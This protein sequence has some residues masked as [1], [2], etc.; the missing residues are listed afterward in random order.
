[1]SSR[2]ANIHANAAAITKQERDVEKATEDLAKERE[3]M[4]KELG[5]YESGLKELGDAGNWLESLERDIGVLEEWCDEREEEERMEREEEERMEREEQERLER[6]ERERRGGD[7]G[8]V[9]DGGGKVEG[10]KSS[11]KWWG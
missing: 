6:E 2:A 9:V 7:A 5:K 10:K 4:N 1:L 11:W 8:G 3:K